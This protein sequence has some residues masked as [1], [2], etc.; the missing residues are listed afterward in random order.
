M[1]ILATGR[2][3]LRTLEHEDAAFYLQLVN[4]PTWLRFIGDK[5]IHKLDEA[6]VAI[7][8]GPIESQRVHG[9]SLYLVERKDSG[10]SVGI[11]GL[12]RRETLPEV[13]LGYA[14]LP[15]HCGQGF[16][17][18]AALAVLT[19]ARE[20]L[21]LKNLLAIVAPDNERSIRLLDA[22]GFRF[23]RRLR[24]RPERD[25]GCLYS[26]ELDESGPRAGL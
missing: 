21:G 1:E 26:L 15:A 16:A 5:G 17:R 22:L 23:E 20:V 7:A 6:R 14:F 18:E 10:A 3:R 4:D 24:L 9:F 11:C 13:D 19:Y 2:L 25:E 12:V 8:T